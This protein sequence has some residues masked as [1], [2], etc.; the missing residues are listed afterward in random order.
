MVF[1]SQ[2]ETSREKLSVAIKWKQLFPIIEK[3]R[4]GAVSGGGLHGISSVAPKFHANTVPPD[5]QI[6]VN[7][8]PGTERLLSLLYLRWNPRGKGRLNPVTDTE[9]NEWIDG[10]L[11][12]EE[13]LDKLEAFYYQ[14]WPLG[15]RLIGLLN[16][17]GVK[18]KVLPD[19]EYA[20][21]YGASHS[22]GQ[23]VSRFKLIHLQESALFERG[24]S[25]VIHEFGHA[26]DHLISSLC[27]GGHQ[28]S[29]KLWHW[30]EPQRRGFVTNYASKDPAEYFAESVE[31]YFLKGHERRLRRLDPKMHA[32]LD[33]LFVMSSEELYF[34]N[35][36]NS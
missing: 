28:M 22:R 20:A 33:D 23:Y 25:T 29:V 5:R 4:V 36:W 11:P 8:P 19:Q 10:M 13:D 35:A 32:F 31:A 7:L 27:N 18:A 9:L 21:Q 15:W 34:S 3:M 12:G 14:T 2:Q 17:F 6:P 24:S 1:L 26:I 16:R 30:F